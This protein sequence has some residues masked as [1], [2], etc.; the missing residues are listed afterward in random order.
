MFN[1][2]ILG[3]IVF[4]LIAFVG[5]LLLALGFRTSF[6]SLTAMQQWGIGLSIGGL[7]ATMAFVMFTAANIVPALLFIGAGLALLWILFHQRAKA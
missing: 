6:A 2:L 5:S 1:W 7:F 3:H 4:G